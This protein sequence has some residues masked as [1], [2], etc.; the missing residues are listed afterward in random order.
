MAWLGDKI[1]SGLAK[2]R[3]GLLSKLEVVIP[4]GR[5]VD[6]ELLMDLED[7]LLGA[8]V[9]L[10]TAEELLER[11]K[12]KADNVTSDEVR[13][14]LREELVEMLSARPSVG[15]DDATT[16]GSPEE[17]EQAAETPESAAVSEK[18]EVILVVG[19][20]GA[21]KTTTVGKLAWRWSGE[22]KKVMVAASDTFRAGA[23]EQLDV[24]IKRSGGDIVR[25]ERGAD[26]AAV[27]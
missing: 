9:G 6:D 27:A 22:G 23:T 10:T 12:Q 3:K 5:K 24:W 17:A 15:A 18:P 2:T 4:G 13:D 19:V 20:N 8:D 16:V 14:I 21:G 26:P 25:Q 11:V 1:K 7:V